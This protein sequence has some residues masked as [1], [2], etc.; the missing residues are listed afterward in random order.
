MGQQ[1]SH[2]YYF[3][4]ILKNIVSFFDLPTLIYENEVMSLQEFEVIFKDFSPVIFRFLLSLC[5]DADLAEELTSE[6]FYQ[7]YLHIGQFRGNCKIETWLC[8]IAKN[9]LFKEQKR[10][11]RI[12][13]LD[14]FEKVEADNKIFDAIAN[15]EQAM[16][17]HKHLHLLKEPYREVFMLRVFGELSFGEIADICGRS[18]VWAK[19]TFYRAKDKLIEDMEG[20][21]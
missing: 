19:V 12:T 6:T 13:G 8:Q 15:K 14:D 17:I 9:A 4:K 11:G 2:R 16:Q 7:A 18:E 10:R 20:L 5:G 1:P 3:K 21:L